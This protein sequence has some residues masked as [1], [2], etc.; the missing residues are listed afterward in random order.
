MTS[1]I[2]RGPILWIGSPPDKKTEQAFL[3][4]RLQIEQTLAPSEA[5]FAIALRPIFSDPSRGVLVGLIK[6]FLGE[7]L[8]HGHNPIILART[9]DIP[10]LQSLWAHA[11]ERVLPRAIGAISANDLA[12]DARDPNACGGRPANMELEIRGCT[13]DHEQE[14]LLK[15]ALWGFSEVH[16]STLV[17]GKSDALVLEA[18]AQRNVGQEAVP[19]GLPI[20]LP[21]LVK[22]EGIGWSRNEKQAF[23]TYVEGQ[24]PFNQRPGFHHNR[25]H[26]GEKFGVIVGD[27]FEGAVSLS[28]VQPRARMRSIIASLFDDG[29][30]SWRALAERSS[31][32]SPGPIEGHLPNGI[33]AGEIS[34]E[35]IAQAE[36]LGGSVVPEDL[37]ARLCTLSANEQFHLGIVHGDLHPGNIMV[38]LGEAVLIDFAYCKDRKAMCAD[39][40]SLEVGL[41]FTTAAAELDADGEEQQLAAFKEWRATVDQL[42]TLQS[43]KAVSHQD[44]RTGSFAWLWDVCRQLRNYR[45]QIGDTERAYALILCAYLLRRARLTSNASPTVESRFAAT[46]LLIAKRLLDELES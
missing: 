2:Q 29:M 43:I 20:A 42:F 39:I 33:R 37:Q 45:Q 17:E 9:E 23:D 38:R 26:M 8:I 41:A 12:E 6:N 10:N 34:E 40:T 24:I 30:R 46:A 15:R 4:R 16:L 14:I 28:K 31:V 13:L 35:V 1:T 32:Y 5:Q 25:C 21:Y 27:F 7:A 18:R 3:E 36:K 19:V 11:A 22:F 44:S